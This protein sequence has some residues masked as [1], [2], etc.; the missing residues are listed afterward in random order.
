MS[1]GSDIE[2][3]LV[4]DAALNITK[5]SGR[6]CGTD[7]TRKAAKRLGAYAVDA[8]GR[9]VIPRAVVEQMARNYAAVG[10]LLRRAQRLA[11]IAG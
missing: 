6:Y 9:G 5:M 10:Y 8:Q 4:R 2:N 1:A 7:A 3:I 11:E